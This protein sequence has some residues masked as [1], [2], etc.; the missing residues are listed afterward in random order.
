[1]KFSAKASRESR[2]DVDLSVAA[3]VGA[4]ATPL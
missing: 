4:R 1:M 3:A 2:I